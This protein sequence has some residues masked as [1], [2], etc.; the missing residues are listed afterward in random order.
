[1]GGDVGAGKMDGGRE[2]FKDLRMGDW[3]RGGGIPGE[4]A[5]NGYQNCFRV[6]IHG[7]RGADQLQGRKAVSG[8][9][10]L[11]GGADHAGSAGEEDS[12]KRRADIDGIDFFLLLMNTIAAEIRVI[13]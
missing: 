2:P 3:R 13:W 10:P 5:G 8:E 7:L 4:L 1:M 6:C 12:R 11:E 9:G